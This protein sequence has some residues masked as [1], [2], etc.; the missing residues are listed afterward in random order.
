MKQWM[1]VVGTA[2]LLA[3]CA[4]QASE[5]SSLTP[6]ETMKVVPLD[7]ETSTATSS[8]PAELPP[9]T[10]SAPATADVA[11]APPATTAVGAIGT[12]TEIQQALKNAGFYS[13]TIDGKIGP[14]SRQA[15]ESFQ[16]A[17]NLTVDGKVGSKTWAK[18]APYAA[19]SGASAGAA[20][21]TTPQ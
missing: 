19:A 1:V 18:L 4:Q 12:T 16:A 9:V 6:S 10:V 13:G 17:N 11:T 2:A 3:G 15:I 8:A 14:K 5:T 21:Y 20:G 7:Q